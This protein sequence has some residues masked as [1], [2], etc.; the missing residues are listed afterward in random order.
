VTDGEGKGC[1]VS[2]MEEMVDPK[3]SDLVKKNLSYTKVARGAIISPLV[4][5]YNLCVEGGKLNIL[6][7][8]IK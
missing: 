8:I 7:E 4:N 6:L 3:P 5:Y 2:S 1:I